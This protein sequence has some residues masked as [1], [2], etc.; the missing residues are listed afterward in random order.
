MTDDLDMGAI[1]NTYG[2]GPDVKLAI[3]AGNDMA[4]ICH[5]PETATTALEHLKEIPSSSIDD[6]LRRIEKLK[7]RLSSPLKFSMKEWHAIDADTMQL[8]IDVLGEQAAKEKR[9][10]TGVKRS[11]VEDY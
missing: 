2:R 5:Q 11:P 7:T 8:R 6:S 10:Y 4:M 9:D 3:S 1:L